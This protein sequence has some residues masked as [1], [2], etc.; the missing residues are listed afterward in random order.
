MNPCFGI[1]RKIPYSIFLA[2]REK[3]FSSFFS[4]R[5]IAYRL[6]KRTVSSSC[7]TNG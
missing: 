6:E 1:D 2:T 5:V 7:A 3:N 4:G